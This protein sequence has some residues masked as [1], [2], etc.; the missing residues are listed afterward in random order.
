M[1]KLSRFFDRFFAYRDTTAPLIIGATGGSGTR[2]F[3]SSLHKAGFFVGTR[4]NH[5]GDAMDFEPFLDEI[6]NP[7]LRE[8]RSLDYTLDQLSGATAKAAEQ[9]FKAALQSY[10][11]DLP[12]D[13]PKQAGL[14]GWKNPRSMYILPIIFAVCPGMS[15]LHLVRDGRDMALSENQN[16]PKKHYQAL[17]GDAYQACQDTGPECA[18]RL[19]AAANSQVADWGERELGNRYMRV[20]FEDVCASPRDVM[21]DTLIKSGIEPAVADRA[22]AGADAVIKAPSSL[23]RWQRLSVEDARILTE[24]CAGTLKR[25]GYQ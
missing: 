11:A 24:K 2:A 21:Y 23:G 3:Q 6:I 10:T 22:S 19:W 13:L 12:K 1:R 25:F 15:F 4:I 17:F 9:G 5:A 14:W 8:T 16:Q 18:I 20:R 7:I